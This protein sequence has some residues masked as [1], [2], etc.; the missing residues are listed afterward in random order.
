MAANYSIYFLEYAYLDDFTLGLAMMGEFNDKV[1]KLAHAYIYLESDEHKIMVDTG[2]SYVGENKEIADFWHLRNFHPVDEVLA[3]IGVKAEDIDIVLLTHAH[4]DHAANM[5]AFPNATF[6]IQEYEL[7]ESI[8]MLHY[9]AKFKNI[10]G[11]VQKENLQEL[12]ELLLEGRLVLINGEE[13]NM[14]PG[15]EFYPA[16]DSHSPGH[17]Y[18]VIRN[19]DEQLPWIC[20]GD[21]VMKYE[22]LTGRDN[23]GAYVPII[24]GG[25][26]HKRC[27]EIYD[28]MMQHVGYNAYRIIP[29]HE[30]RIC[31]HYP[32][33]E[34][35]ENIYIT[36]VHLAD[37]KNSKL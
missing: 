6:Y 33:K 2:W 14:I 3:Q 13:K 32:S 27:V 7:M 36:E 15:I 23:D 11:A 4:F 35:D 10:V 1:T 17:Q 12:L 29:Q 20:C 8:K 34:W 19:D 9:P 28:E 37:G 21:L 31:E 26:S 22:N 24:N 5:K 30:P 16:F 18:I 25:G